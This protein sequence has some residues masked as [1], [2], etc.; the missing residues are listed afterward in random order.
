MRTFCLTIFLFLLHVT[1]GYSMRCVPPEQEELVGMADMIFEGVILDIKRLPNGKFQDPICWIAESE[2]SGFNERCGSKILHFQVKHMWKGGDH[3]ELFIFSEDG[4]YCCGL[5]SPELG[6]SYVVFAVVA[7]DPQMLAYQIDGEYLLG[8]FI[9]DKDHLNEL[10]ALE[11][12][13][14][15]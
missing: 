2:A 12:L 10:R 8:S 13:L 11:L 14:Q 9:V 15:K 5:S 4:C 6:E 3:Q 7:D 1:S